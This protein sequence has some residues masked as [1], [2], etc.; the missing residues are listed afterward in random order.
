MTP[1]QRRL[2]LVIGILAGVSIAGVLALSAFRKNVTFFF[3]P[4]QVVAGQ[5]PAGERF[6]LGGMVTEGSLKRAPGSLEVRF[7]VTDFSHEVPVSYTGV[8]PD[9]FREG[10]GVVAH[11]HLG[12]DGTFIADEV[13]AKHDEKYMP[14]EVARSLKRR[15][16]ES[17]TES[18]SAT[19]P[20]GAAPAPAAAPTPP[21]T[22]SAGS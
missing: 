17:R 9:L 13:L 22:P 2:T 1:R 18:D 20:P 7:V 4:T 12:R 8:L 3:D 14:P 15:H 6:R 21:A 10:A 16:G 5:V 11:G 19:S